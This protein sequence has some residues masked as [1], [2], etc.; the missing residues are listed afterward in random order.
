M[1]RALNRAPAAPWRQRD[2][3]HWCSWLLGQIVCTAAP[4]LPASQPLCVLAFSCS[5]SEAVDLALGCLEEVIALYICLCLSLLMEGAEVSVPLRC[6]HLD[7]PR[8]IWNLSTGK[9]IPQERRQR[10]KECR[11]RGKVTTPCQHCLSQ[12]HP[13]PPPNDSEKMGHRSFSL[14]M[15]HQ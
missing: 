14:Q 13:L 7:L 1:A 6:L 5:F 15:K 9:Y 4:G 10:W 12:S 8:A 3:E 2:P 11:Q